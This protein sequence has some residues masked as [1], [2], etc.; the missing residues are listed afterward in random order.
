MNLDRP[1]I[2]DNRLCRAIVDI[3]N[4]TPN[5]G[6]VYVVGSLRARGLI[7]SRNRVRGHLQMIDP[8]RRILRRRQAIQRRRYKVKGANYL[9]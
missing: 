9:W 4:I 1:T 6:E 8:V 5:A 3:L 7:V 2:S